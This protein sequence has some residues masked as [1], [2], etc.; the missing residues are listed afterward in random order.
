M[1]VCLRLWMPKSF[2]HF[3]LFSLALS[4]YRIIFI[5]LLLSQTQCGRTSVAVSITPFTW[6]WD[7]G[8]QFPWFPEWFH[9]G[10]RK[11]NDKQPE[12]RRKALR[13]SMRD[14]NEKFH[15]LSLV[16]LFLTEYL[17]T[18]C[19]QCI[20]GEEWQFVL[21]CA[22]KGQKQMMGAK[23]TK[24]LSR[25]YSLETWSCLQCT[26]RHCWFLFVVFFA[27]RLEIVTKIR[28]IY[29]DCST[30]TGTISRRFDADSKVTRKR[31]VICTQNKRITRM[32]IE[33]GKKGFSAFQVCSVTCQLDSFRPF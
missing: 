21:R 23:P 20:L 13:D 27:A 17:Q 26:L 29:L 14:C 6:C 1:C 12:E 32:F 28:Q 8:L 30:Q 33:T 10:R 2:S 18:L 25:G 9:Y 11:T 5:H 16:P 7:K 3:S 31:N 4:L 19:S 15:F 22:H 24:L